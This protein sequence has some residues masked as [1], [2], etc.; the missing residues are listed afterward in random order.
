MENNNMNEVSGAKIASAL[1]KAQGMM[2]GAKKDT[3]NEFFKSS[4][5]SLASVFDAIRQPFS[6][7]NLAVTQVVNILDDG[8]QVLCTRLL[9]SS[10]EFIES[11][12]LLP[13]EPNP[14]KLGSLITYLRRY[15]LMSIA[16]IPSEDDDCNA[17]SQSMAHAAPCCDHKQIAELQDIISDFRNPQLIHDKILSQLGIK[18]MSMLPKSKYSVICNWAKQELMKESVADFDD[19]TAP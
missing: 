6:E 10:G 4:Y 7:N 15:S 12:M 8:K 1:S 17:A 3:K 13:P 16:G 14:Q 5:A 11:K 18:N 9:H 2:G 19:S